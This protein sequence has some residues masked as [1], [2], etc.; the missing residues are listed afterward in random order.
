MARRL[1]IKA[2]VV[3]AKRNGKSVVNC[4][5]DHSKV[6]ILYCNT[7]R[8]YKLQTQNDYNCLTIDKVATMYGYYLRIVR[9]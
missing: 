7:I 1:E 4:G 5:T 9:S 6:N 8:N 3:S 2:Y